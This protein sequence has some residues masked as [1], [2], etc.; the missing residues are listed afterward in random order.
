MQINIVSN[1]TFAPIYDKNKIIYNN[2]K[3]KNVNWNGF[4]TNKNSI[5]D[6]K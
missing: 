2:E 6:T 5:K 1:E 4:Y 3:Y